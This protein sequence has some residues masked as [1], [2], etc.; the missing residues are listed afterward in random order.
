MVRVILISTAFLFFSL[1]SFSQEDTTDVFIVGEKSEIEKDTVEVI[2]VGATNVFK[3]DAGRIYAEDYCLSFEHL[4]DDDRMSLEYE[5]SFAL[6]VDKFWFDRY[7]RDMIYTVDNNTVSHQGSLDGNYQFF[8]GAGVTFKRYLSKRKSGIYGFYLG[9]KVK[10]RFG[11]TDLSGPIDSF[12]GHINL[13]EL[14]PV[15]G[16]SFWLWDFIVIDPFL[17]P[18]AVIAF[19]KH[20]SL[21]ENTSGMYWEPKSTTFFSPAIHFGLR[22]GVEVGNFPSLLF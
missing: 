4:I 11:T 17:G 14:I 20:A 12:R 18:S 15:A 7:T 3:F 13:L 6:E 2:K 9:G 8:A 10:N 19:T 22:V 21:E 5:L 1:F 16:Y